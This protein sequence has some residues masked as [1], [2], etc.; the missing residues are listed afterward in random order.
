MAWAVQCLGHPRR[1]LLRLAVLL[2]LACSMAGFVF[3]WAAH[4]EAGLAPTQNAWSATVA[5]L[6][7]WQGL[8]VGVLLVMGGYLLARSLAGRLRA[9]ARATLDNSALFWHY[10]VAQGLATIGL[11]RL[12]PEWLG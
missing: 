1:W 3:D 5:A 11:V 4:H 9:D 10:A 6:L 8:H 2:A 7:A 12:L